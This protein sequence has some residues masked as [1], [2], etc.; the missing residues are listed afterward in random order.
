MIGPLQDI[1]DEPFLPQDAHERL[2]LAHRN[3]LRLLKLVNTL[4]DFSR[5]EADRIEAVYEP[6]DLPAL[7]AE[8]ASNFRSAI[9]RAGLTFTVDCDP[10]SESVYVDREMWEKIVLNLLSNAFKFTLSGGIKLKLRQARR[11]VELLVSDTGTG[12]PAEA[13][14]RIFE[15]FHRVKGARGRSYEGSGIGLALV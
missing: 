10:V 14:P 8:L 6:V 3:S 5:I 13:L 9:E 7:T 1:L 4:L 12:I 2:S 15:R 11:T